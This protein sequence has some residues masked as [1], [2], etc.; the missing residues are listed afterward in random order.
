M[1]PAA[2]LE[3]RPNTTSNTAVINGPVTFSRAD[4][5]VPVG[6]LAGASTRAA[7]RGRVP[8]PGPIPQFRSTK[9]VR[10]KGEARLR[11]PKQ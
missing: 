2:A 6:L 4:V 8:I 9:V 10:S 1:T 7:T 11:P 3:L 5:A